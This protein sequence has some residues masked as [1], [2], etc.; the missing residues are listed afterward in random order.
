VFDYRADQ[1]FCFHGDRKSDGAVQLHLVRAA[2]SLE[3][4][5]VSRMELEMT[6]PDYDKGWNDAIEA[7]AAAAEKE[8]ASCEADNL[9]TMAEQN[10][11]PQGARAAAEAIRKLVRSGK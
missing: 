9:T 11:F 6:N 3:H 7:A 8:A 1:F 2:R 4:I 5:F 10:W